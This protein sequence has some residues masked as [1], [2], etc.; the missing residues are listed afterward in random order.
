MKEGYGLWLAAL[1]GETQCNFM[2]HLISSD[3]ADI[4][5]VLCDIPIHITIYS[6]I[7]VTSITRLWY[8]A[9]P[10]ND[11]DRDE[12]FRCHAIRQLGEAFLANREN[13]EFAEVRVIKVLARSTID[14]CTSILHLDQATTLG[15]PG[16]S[17]IPE[18]PDLPNLKH[19]STWYS[20]VPS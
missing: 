6:R 11:E 3:V 2:N 9:F 10:L 5:A 4:K 16:D 17:R 8:H 7:E 1:D 19:E 20:F 15:E 18:A 13:E 12:N 14:A